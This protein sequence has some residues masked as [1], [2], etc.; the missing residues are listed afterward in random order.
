MAGPRRALALLGAAAALTGVVAEPS[1]HVA[2]SHS[3][4]R[5]SD[6]DSE[7]SSESATTTQPWTVI[8][9]STCDGKEVRNVACK[10]GPC[11]ECEPIDCKLK[12]WS[13]WSDGD[14]TGLCQRERD[15]ATQKN[16]CGE[17]CKGS[18]IETKSCDTNCHKLPAVC[19]DSV[20]CEWGQWSD[21]GA[22][23]APCGGG[24][25]TRYRD[26]KSSP[27]GNGKLCESKTKSEV[28]PC[29]MQPCRDGHC[30]DGKWSEWHTWG[31]CSAT[32]GGGVR[33]RRR[34]IVVEANECGVPAQGD[35]KVFEEC[36]IHSC[37]RDIDCE[38]TG[39]GRWSDCS[40]PCDGV[41]HRSREI[42][43]HGQ[44][45]G[46]FC[47]NSTTEVAPCNLAKHTPGCSP[48]VDPPVDC[49]LSDWG[50]WESCSTTCGVGQTTRARTILKH[51][52]NGGK[53]CLG[54]LTLSSSCRDQPLCV[55]HE[56]SKPCTWGEWVEW[57]ACDH[58]GGERKRFRHIAQMPENG[59]AVCDPKASEEI[60]KCPRQCHDR[61]VCEWGEWGESSECSVTCGEGI[62]RHTRYL[63]AVSQ[64]EL[65]DSVETDG[66]AG[67]QS[68]HLQ[69]DFISDFG[70][71]GSEGTA[72]EEEEDASPAVL[73]SRL[74]G[75][76]V[77]FLAGAAG[78][79]ALW[80]GTNARRAPRS[81]E[82]YHA[83]GHPGSEDHEESEELLGPRGGSPW[84][85]SEAAGGLE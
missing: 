75:A 68:K 25:R 66:E 51:A 14:C 85:R 3:L 23:T 65:A 45:G 48:P 29:R 60:G 6:D 10:R 84:L 58:C 46:K 55:E 49:L 79:F 11:K 5:H 21:W 44:A 73:T 53:P 80:A 18:F 69:R 77:G 9:Q 8:E 41:M 26:I 27:Q 17:P 47:D 40:C 76:S 71:T 50:E 36:N 64:M 15:I 35:D 63:K 12:E 78:M 22:C 37:T 38:F 32:C 82:G 54:A 57:G 39:W 20:D 62:V 43:R 33:W 1:S 30:I 19:K 7:A 24:Q 67:E 56:T 31:M 4:A 74:E 34:H 61:Y 59:G 42:A 2:S 52:E 16:E 83:V 28:A 13:D 81:P 70:I 72:H